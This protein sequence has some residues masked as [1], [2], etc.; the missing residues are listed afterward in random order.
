MPREIESYSGNAIAVPLNRAM[1]KW[2]FDKV[3]RSWRA[4]FRKA[5]L[6]FAQSGPQRKRVA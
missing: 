1:M 3:I 6:S 4:G 5:S 2:L